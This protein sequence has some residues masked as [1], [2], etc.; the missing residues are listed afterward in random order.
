MIGGTGVAHA[1]CSATLSA[2]LRHSRRE[3]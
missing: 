2:P 1:C 3:A